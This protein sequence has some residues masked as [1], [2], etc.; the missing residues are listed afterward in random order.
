MSKEITKYGV[1]NYFQKI[2]KEVKIEIYDPVSYDQWK[3][4]RGLEPSKFRNDYNWYVQSKKEQ[5]ESEV[6]RKKNCELEVKCKH[7]SL[8]PAE[9]EETKQTIKDIESNPRFV[10]WCNE[11][12]IHAILNY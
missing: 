11:D 6:E 1:V 4:L 5:F 8:H 10:K 3:M 2:D 12:T 7:Y 9:I